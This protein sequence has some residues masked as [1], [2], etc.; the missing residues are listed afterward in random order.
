MLVEEMAEIIEKTFGDRSLKWLALMQTVGW[1]PAFSQ[2]QWTQSGYD[3]N[4]LERLIRNG[5]I[6]TQ[7]T[8]PATLSL[9][10]GFW[11]NLP[12]VMSMI[13]SLP[14]KSAISELDLPQ[15]WG[16]W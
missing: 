4:E 10:D 14:E 6:R 7:P 1:R 11:K 16:T 5:I 15:T 9:V 12:A 3:L 13:A 8:P 2:Q